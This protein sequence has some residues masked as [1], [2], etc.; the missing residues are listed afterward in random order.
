MNKH[1]FRPHS[2]RTRRSGTFCR[3]ADASKRVERR[4]PLPKRIAA[5]A[6]PQLTTLKKVQ[7]LQAVG[8]FGCLAVLLLP[9]KGELLLTGKLCLHCRGAAWLRGAA[10]RWRHLDL[11][12]LSILSLTAHGTACQ[13]VANKSHKFVTV[14]MPSPKTVQYLRFYKIHNHGIFSN[15][16]DMI[17]RAR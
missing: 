15:K 6:P 13:F 3:I 8:L 4:S 16:H 1:V 9:H 10:I 14:N 2:E 17:E 12:T 5:A 11:S 7:T